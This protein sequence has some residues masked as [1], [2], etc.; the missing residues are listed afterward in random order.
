MPA[1]EARASEP[2]FVTYMKS[3]MLI[4]AAALACAAGAAAF[5][6]GPS[7]QQTSTVPDR[8]AIAK[9]SARF[10]PVDI[11]ADVAAIQARRIVTPCVVRLSRDPPSALRPAPRLLLRSFDR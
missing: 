1:R 11:K 7:V 9:M 3:Q 6:R 10:A 5:E 4:A 2:P 8:A